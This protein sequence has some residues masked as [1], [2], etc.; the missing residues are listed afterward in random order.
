MSEIDAAVAN[1]LLNLDSWDQEIYTRYGKAVSDRMSAESQ[2]RRDLGDAA[3][4][5]VDEF[6]QIRAGIAMREA[7]RHGMELGT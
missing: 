7:R 2:R 5:I 6:P 4:E 1:I 3:I